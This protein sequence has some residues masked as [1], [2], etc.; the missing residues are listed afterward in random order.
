[1]YCIKCGLLVF[2]AHDFDEA[3]LLEAGSTTAEFG[4]YLQGF[5]HVVTHG[6]FDFEVVPEA[7]LGFALDPC[8]A[9]SDVATVDG[10]ALG[11]DEFESHEGIDLAFDECLDVVEVV[12]ADF[13]FSQE[14]HDLGA[15]GSQDELVP[16]VGGVLVPGFAFLQKL[17]G[18]SQF[19]NGE[20]IFFGCAG[21]DVVDSNGLAVAEFYCLESVFANIVCAEESGDHDVVHAAASGCAKTFDG[22]G[23]GYIHGA[24]LFGIEFIVADGFGE[25]AGAHG[26]AQ[27]GDFV[28][29]GFADAGCFFFEVKD[30]ELVEEDDFSAEIPGDGDIFF[31]SGGLLL[32]EGSPLVSVFD[33]IVFVDC[34]SHNS[35][36]FV[37]LVAV[38]VGLET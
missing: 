4:A 2:L 33:L 31:Q 13:G 37:F 26:A 32:E 21:F 34:C 35:D 18:G 16:E 27:G 7:E 38:A 24:E 5:I 20:V 11:A 30:A 1:M 9:G 3:F 8:E 15:C 28:E 17:E 10:Q 14:T 12:A 19:G 25:D 23:D 6:E 36:G 29:D 22:F